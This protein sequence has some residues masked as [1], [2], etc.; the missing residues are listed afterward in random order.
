MIKE[1]EKATENL[2]K[3][4]ETGKG[5]DVISAQIEKRQSERKDLESQLAYETLIHPVLTFDEV[6]YFLEKFKDGD[7]ND[8]VY[9]TALI[10]TF[11]RK[12]YVFDGE[13][14]RIEI[15]CNASDTSINCTIDKPV[16]GS[17]MAQLARLTRP[18][19]YSQFNSPAATGSLP[20]NVCLCLM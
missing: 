18:L 1:N 3:A 19:C 5:V 8:I 12:I 17:S 15:Y 7:I 2:I 20:C 14:A 11:V 10:D 6:K 16:K 4:I 9:R 13:D